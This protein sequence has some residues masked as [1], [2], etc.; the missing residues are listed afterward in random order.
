M[1]NSL[2]IVALLLILPF[3]GHAAPLQPQQE[4]AVP[5]LT[6]RVTDLTGTLDSQQQ[7]ALESR[8]AAV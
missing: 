5:Q 4:V 1:L 2:R 7:Q 8:L 3:A 6:Q